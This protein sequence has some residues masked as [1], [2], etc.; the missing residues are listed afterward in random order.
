MSPLVSTRLDDRG[1]RMWL[2]LLVQPGDELVGHLV[3]RWG[4]PEVATRLSSGKPL[5]GNLVSSRVKSV[6]AQRYPSVPPLSTITRTRRIIEARGLGITIPGDPHW[7]TQLGDLGSAAPLLLC[8]AGDLRVV[9]ADRARVAIVGTRKP[10]T[11]AVMA[12]REIAAG[13]VRSGRTIV[14]GGARGID[15]TAH[16]VA[17]DAGVPTVAVVAQSPDRPYPP[18]HRG[19]LGDIAQSGVVL[20][21]TLPGVQRG[22]EGFLARNRL[23]AALSN[24]TI[25]TEAPWRSG[26]MSTAAHAAKLQ[27]E[28]VAV[29]YP[30]HQ[31]RNDGAVRIL[32]QWAATEL[33]W[34][35]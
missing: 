8:S 15:A 17:L 27:R 13:Q 3:G 21:E 29:T 30:N 33:A 7:P 11:E 5:S 35:Q 18:E 32:E 24:L 10:S 19:L 22:P 23:I 28:V 2:A 26:A 34:P 14:S 16:A 20:G 25:V 1:A 31:S 6:L 12:T 4:A 9:S